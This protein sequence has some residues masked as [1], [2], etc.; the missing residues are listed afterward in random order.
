MQINT[1]HTTTHTNDI[2]AQFLGYKSYPIRRM[3]IYCEE[4]YEPEDEHMHEE[5]KLN[6]NDNERRHTK[7]KV[8]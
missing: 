7:N 1:N 5:C 3:C 2:G 8:R 6:K 4:I